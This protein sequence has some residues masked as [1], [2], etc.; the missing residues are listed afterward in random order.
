VWLGG[1]NPH[2]TGEWVTQQARNLTMA[3]GERATR[4]TFLVR[5]RDAKFVAS[6]DAVFA[7]DGARIL[8]APVRTPRKLVCGAM[9][10]QRSDQ[11]PGLDPDLEPPPSQEGAAGL[12]HPLQ[13]RQ[14]SPGHRPR[15]PRGARQAPTPHGTDQARVL[16]GLIHEYYR[17]A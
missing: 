2:P 9:S 4:I 3:L 8:K 10:P 17:A 1:V 13:S 7:A 16:S 5:D 15:G 14:P 11:V 12:R 6:F